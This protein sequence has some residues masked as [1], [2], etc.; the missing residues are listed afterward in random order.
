[1]TEE[2]SRLREEY[3][4]S[5]NWKRWGPYVSER[6]WST[7]RE[8]YSQDG[9]SWNYFSHDEAR[10]RAYRWGE[11]GILGICDRQCRLTFS[12]AMWNGKDSILK[13]RLYGLTGEEG[14]H[15]EDVKE[16]YF[17]LDSSPTHSYMKGL[18]KYPQSEYPYPDLVNTNNNRSRYESEYEIHDTGIFDKS[19]YFDVYAEYSKGSD[20]D[21]LIRLKIVNQ[22]PDSAHIHIIPTLLYRNTWAWGREGEG[23][24]DRPTIEGKDDHL[25]C[26]EHDNLGKFHFAAREATEWIFTNNET[27]NEKLFSSLNHTPYTKDAFHRYI[28]GGE[29]KCINFLKTGTKVGAL[30]KRQVEAGDSFTLDYRLWMD[31]EDVDIDS[32]FGD[33]E[34]IFQKRILET[35]EYYNKILTNISA[36]QYNIARQA[37]AGLLWTK[38]Y[39]N[40]SIKEWLEGDPS[41]PKPSE[42]RE[43]VRNSEWKHLHNRDI[44][45]MPDKWEY[46]WYAS[47]DLAFH[48]IPFTYIDPYFAKSQLVLFLREW[49]MHPNG[50]IPAYEYNF[51]DVN[52]PVHAWAVWKVYKMNGK[53]DINF[54]HRCFLKLILN[55]TW[56]VNM[57]DLNGN[58]IFSGGFLGLD[59]ISIF[60]RSHT[61]GLQQADATS[62][63]AFFCSNMLNISM[64]LAKHFP[65]IEDIASKF[66]EHYVAIVDSM[67]SF[68]GTGLWNEEDGF[69]YDQLKNDRTSFPLRIRSMVGL[70]PICAVNLLKRNV[71][72]NLPGFKKRMNWYIENRED[73]HQ[74][75]SYLLPDKD[76]NSPKCKYLLAIPTE[77]RLRRVLHYML[78]EDEFLSEFGIR[79]LSKYYEDN[80]YTFN[81]DSVH[82][83]PGESDTGMFGGNSNWRGPIWF[84][85]NTLIIESLRKYYRY[86]GDR[87]QVEC[88]THSGNYMNLL[89]I[90]KEISS[91]LVKMFE[92]DKDGRR[93]AHGRVQQFSNDENWKELLLFYE[94]FDGDTGE[95]LGA[96][97]Q[98]GWTALISHLIIN[99]THDHKISTACSNVH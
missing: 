83:I 8:D 9:D 76:E 36:D 31:G 26:L 65:A 45:S 93:P 96:S 30:V 3:T 12:L 20:N 7:V 42:N 6:Q 41:F 50:M 79:S 46:P 54:L 2:E 44:I 68:E 77:E 1:M 35:D 61:N 64:E 84:P 18:Y 43:D 72:D 25:L 95:G 34:D 86:F 59:N 48:M 67:N 51:S 91:R 22:G 49:Y 37:F 89:D 92:P 56:W 29:E 47:W 24:W 4:R 70:I 39:Y 90:S 99:N 66:F 88:P 28:I 75:M 14:N 98:T 40:Y 80:P 23:Y 60:D 52:P 85:V 10:S 38:Q 33:F 19:R 71:I 11:D 57:K 15:G 81:G 63:V 53:T 94:Y 13:E 5:K 73:L 58:N 32:P 82:Y 27:N 16:H 74:S 87:F 55:F 78:D 17:Y 21:I 69:Y 97:H 62:W